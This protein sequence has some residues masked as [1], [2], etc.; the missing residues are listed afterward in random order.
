MKK[1]ITLV[2]LLFIVTVS[3]FGQLATYAGAGGGGTT[4]T[5]VANET[6]TSLLNSGFGSNTPC[7]SGGLS[8]ITVSTTWSTYSTAGPRVYIQMKP[9]AGYQLNVTGINAGM[10]R[11]G[12]GPACV[13]FAYSLDNGVTW[14]DDLACH[15]PINSGCGTTAVS[16]WSGGTLPT[17]ITST[18]NGI[19]VALFPYI[20]SS[21]SG[22]FQVNTFNVLG[23]VTVSCTP[24][25][26][27][28]G[29][30]SLCKGSST[31]LTDATTGGTWSSSNTSVATVGV[32]GSVAGVAAGTSVITYSTGA[33]CTA[34][35]IVTVNPLPSSISGNTNI[36]LGLTS[37]LSDAG[38]GTWLSSNSSVATVGL[39]TGLVSS[40]STGTAV[41]TYTLGT[42]CAISTIV[43]VNPTP[44][45]ISGALTVCTGLTTNLSDL[46]TGGS[47]SSGSTTI[48]T[49]SGGIVTGVSA[50]TSTISYALTTGCVATTVVTVYP[51]PLGIVAPA[52]ICTGFPTLLSDPTLGG[53]WS[54]GNSS[55]AT[56]SSGTSIV[57]GIL[58]GTTTIT[59]TLATG[60][61]S[62]FAMTVNALPAGITGGSAVCVGL[63]GA[64]SDAT[65]TG[66]WSSNTTSVATIGSTSGIYLGVSSGTS[67]ITYTTAAGCPTII[68]VTVN[69]LPPVIG[70]SWN[71]CVG[72]Q[73][74]LIE[75]GGGGWTSS[76]TS[77]AT[78]DPITGVVSGLIPGTTTITYTIG[79]GCTTT[80][81]VTVNPLPPGITGTMN[82]CPGTTAVLSD[83][84]G[85]TWSS[86]NTSYATIGL[87]TGVY[88]GVSS[89]TA[90][91][92][93][94]SA[95]GCIATTPV[96]VN[97][98]P[99]P[100][101]GTVNVCAGL[102]TSLSDATIGGTWSS[103]NSSVATVGSVSAVITGVSPGTAIIVY[104]IPTGCAITATV[105]VN[106]LPSSMTGTMAV[107]SGLTTTL[108]DAGGGTWS[109]S[110]TSVATVTLSG[111]GVVTGVTVG[112]AVI[113]YTLVTGCIGTGTVT[114]NPLP[115]AIT[116]TMTVCQGA[117]TILSDATLSGSWSSS[118]SAIAAI[119]LG[120]GL[121]S[122]NSGG[123][124]NIT[125]TLITTG[126][127]ITAPVIV[128]PTAPIT[129]I[130][131]VCAGSVVLLS[132]VYSGGTWVSS[133]IGVAAIGS[134]TGVLTGVSAGTSSITYTSLTG[135]TVA[136]VV[137]I[138]PFP[139][140]IFGSPVLCTGSTTGLSDVPAGGSWASSNSAVATIDP[141]TGV[142]SGL[143]VGSTIITY[144]HGSG[145]MVTETVTVNL[146]VSPITGAKDMCGGG[147]TMLVADAD[148]PR[149]I[150][151]STLVT[152]TPVGLA[153]AYKT[154]MGIITYTLPTGCFTT[155]SLTVDPVPAKII[156]QNI[157]CIG[158]VSALSDSTSGG[159]WNSIDPSISV[160]AF[161]GLVTSLT[162][163]TAVVSYSLPTGCSATDTMSVRPIP[164][165]I[166]GI[167]NICAGSST[168]LSDA[169]SGGLWTSAHT[170]TATIDP[171]TG[172]VMGVAAGITMI[173][174]SI[175]TS[176]S[177]N[178]TVT[179]LP[180]PSVYS[181]T[182]GGSYCAG[183][184]GV[185]IFLSSSVTGTK[186]LLYN[187]SYYA[188]SIAGFGGLLDYGPITVPGV[189]GIVARD[190]VTGCS[191]NMYS[192]VPVIA[193]PIVTPSLIMVAPTGD[194]VC[195]GT[196][197]TFTVAPVNGGTLPKYEWVVNGVPASST[198]TSYNYSPLD[199]DVVVAAMT[200]NATCADPV[201]AYAYVTMSVVTPVVPLVTISAD[202]G[203]VVEKGQPVTFTALVVN[204]GI[205]PAYQWM[206]NGLAVAGETFSTYTTNSIA[207]F[208]SISCMVT[209]SGL[210][211]L[212]ATNRVYMNVTT[213]GVGSLTNLSSVLI[214]PNPSKGGFMISGYSGT[215][216]DEEVTIEIT[217][218]VGQ[219]I[220]TSKIKTD[221]GNIEA[222]VELGDNFA[223][224]NYLLHIRSE[225]IYKTL[226][227]V[228]EK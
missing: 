78:V 113:T 48:A 37:T 200:S 116:G 96:T 35:T 175:G 214:S 57:T 104:T 191:N 61:T 102:T 156:G 84:A 33:G 89:G 68:T 153:T 85:G 149:G 103:L 206:K 28:T 109:S 173:T 148:A 162:T 159:L 59:Y 122:G 205:T 185:H 60:C 5:G 98:L 207:N 187:G 11:S 222:H 208:D 52:N 218:M 112:T 16:N 174:Y 129:G 2:A 43:T 63:T 172:S 115:L 145:C 77:V 95:V 3:S 75:G 111:A 110:N 144:D 192:F 117:S 171:V 140:G 124:A 219:V 83:V 146:A 169:V 14:I 201:T 10:R 19:I 202:P 195:A 193:N 197:V 125:Y 45:T 186:Y 44:A 56:F 17:G 180:L 69:L 132:A 183:D 47:W 97:P 54:S 38:S 105:T 157:L 15:A 51:L 127:I 133:N 81:N 76:N 128:N 20:P 225:N 221:N 46:T 151:T 121:V 147:A 23:N 154:G 142:V 155:V 67:V 41:I 100:I 65:P 167:T 215:A 18:V 194:T 136:A 143:L 163:G 25:L 196:P 188:D 152:I 92:T 26:A 36:C 66:T 53:T 217:D 40:V 82:V 210:C 178:T 209:G 179:V 181:V 86:S 223:A 30:G 73:T 99:L 87:G 1:L 49:V 119:G 220:Y 139:A 211:G 158:S 4:V 150:W 31:A 32:G 160:D 177:V 226:Q 164:S 22:T 189:Y 204:G 203:T 138:D 198:G 134:G 7:S 34:T 93:Y 55:V 170:G 131:Y 80:A 176:C 62:T 29:T 74:S 71:A 91:I 212:S 107:C 58:A 120:S 190:T 70:G 182:G 50:G 106:S 135:C 126:C 213:D 24:P 13:R 94:T 6:V 108:S 166:T 216:T 227:V 161:T 165:A 184:T 168:P 72:G 137:T 228:I 199:E 27:I 114:V 101:L 224:G 8:G 118:N 130:P 9:L 123:V 42:G 12:T 64:L 88:S 79:T 141:V 21:S 90:T 39:G